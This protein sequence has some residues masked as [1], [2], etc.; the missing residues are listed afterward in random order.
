[1]H[2][3]DTTGACAPEAASPD[4]PLSRDDFIALFRLDERDLADFL[5]LAIRE[6]GVY[7]IQLPDSLPI[8]PEERGAWPHHP[9]GVPSRRLFAFPGTQAQALWM[10]AWL[11][12]PGYIDREDLARWR[13]KK[14]A[15]IA[16]YRRECGLSA[17]AQ[18]AA[19][20][21]EA[22]AGTRSHVRGRQ[23]RL[24][25]RKAVVS[26]R[27]RQIETVLRECQ[28]RAEEKGI[29]FDRFQI[30]AKLGHF[31]HVLKTQYQQ[32]WHIQ[33]KDY[34]DK[35]APKPGGFANRIPDGENAFRELFQ[36]IEWKD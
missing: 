25:V 18:E 22:V 9:L 28:Q 12:S 30:R 27:E 26:E 13:T 36:E 5:G 11:D 2:P 1:M 35:L 20:G 3:H 15:E 16:K 19:R 8:T 23:A 17:G 7:V 6:D 10:E 32:D 29:P 4:L 33:F 31:H 14:A 24:E 21:P 34:W